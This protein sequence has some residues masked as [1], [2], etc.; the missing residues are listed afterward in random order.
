M[1]LPVYKIGIF[2]FMSLRGQIEGPRGQLE[3]DQRP[4]VD[5]TEILHL[6]NRGTPF[7]L[8]SIVDCESYAAAQ[9]IYRGYQAAELH[10]A[11]GS[12]PVVQ[13]D[14][15]TITHGYKCKVLGVRLLSIRKAAVIVGGLQYTSGAILECE[16]TLIGIST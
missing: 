16:W 10:S 15:D 4:G 1:A 7:T 3:I 13:N 12:S 11:V 9:G 14:Y 8:T 6:R 2:E 5:G